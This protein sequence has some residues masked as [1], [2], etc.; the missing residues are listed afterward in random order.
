MDGDHP[1]RRRRRRRER[2]V[3]VIARAAAAAA[4]AVILGSG[5]EMVDE[6]TD[7]AMKLNRSITTL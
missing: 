4:A 7:G 3:F 6:R 2:S 5:I 1:G